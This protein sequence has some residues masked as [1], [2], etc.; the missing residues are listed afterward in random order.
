MNSDHSFISIFCGNCGHYISIPEH[1]GNR[2]CISCSQQRSLKIRRKLSTFIRDNVIVK[3]YTYQHVTLTIK[4]ETDLKRMMQALVKGFRRLRQR[5]YWKQNVK[6]GAFVVEI[7]KNT[8]LWHA[9]LHIV[10]EAKWLDWYRIREDWFAC[11]GGKG[12]YIQ[13][14]PASEIVKYVTKYITKSEL[15][16]DNQ[17][18]ATSAIKGMRMFQPFGSWH[19]P[20]LAIKLP[21]YLCPCCEDRDWIFG[22][23]DSFFKKLAVHHDMPIRP[24]PMAVKV[25]PQRTLCL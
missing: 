3:P 14:I 6:G 9:H 24:P 13:R 18:E 19:N 11:S 25:D 22:T 17:W 20:L 2:F 16:L 8:G 5:S 7:T 1:C 10:V 23:Y 15:S 21:R 4:N 12:V